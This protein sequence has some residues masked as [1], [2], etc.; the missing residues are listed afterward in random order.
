M[1]ALK[2]SQD[3]IEALINTQNVYMTTDCDAMMESLIALGEWVVAKCIHPILLSTTATLYDL[4][5]T[6]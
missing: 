1:L 3:I 4:Y 5:L 2:W 6:L